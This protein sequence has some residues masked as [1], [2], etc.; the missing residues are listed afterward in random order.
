MAEI[1]VDTLSPAIIAEGVIP[2]VNNE[3]GAPHSVQTTYHVRIEIGNRNEVIP[4]YGRGDVKIVV[5]PQSL[6]SRMVRFFSDTFPSF[7]ELWD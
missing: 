5:E 4:L 3:L 6:G 7:H 1:S 2:Q